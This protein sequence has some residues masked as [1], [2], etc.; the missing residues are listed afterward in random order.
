MYNQHI[1]NTCKSMY[2]HLR[3]IGSIR[4]YVSSADCCTL[5]HAVV[6]TKLD[7]CNSLLYGLPESVTN[8]LQR[9]QNTAARIITQSK[10]YEHITPTLIK[11]HWL[12]VRSRIDYKI[13]LLTYKAIH[14]LT[15]E[16]IS[17]LIQ[18]YIPA[19]TLRS[20]DKNL[21]TTT[22]YK[23]INYGGRSFAYAAPKLWNSL[24]TD[25]KLA[26]TI[27]CFKRKLK[28]HLFC[29]AYGVD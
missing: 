22:S 5:I 3:R 10:K 21:L 20:K 25:I 26:P 24:P 9:A 7:Y 29:K 17:D 16:Y 2:C 13:L 1:K 4:Q 11:L 8:Q 23:Q 14:G 15:P 19:R 18:V 28:T 27:D 6:S 12:P